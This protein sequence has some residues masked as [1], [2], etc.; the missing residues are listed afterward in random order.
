MKPVFLISLLLVICS[1]CQ[2]LAEAETDN[3][4]VDK[5]YSLFNSSDGTGLLY[6]MTEFSKEVPSTDRSEVL[7][8]II[9]QASKKPE[10]SQVIANIAGS[11]YNEGASFV[12]SVHLERSLL[13]QVK[14]G[15]ATVRSSII[16]LL[17]HKEHNKYR[18]ICLSSLEDPDDHVRKIAVSSI[19]RW[20]DGREI[21]SKY[22]KDHYFSP[23][24]NASVQKAE[25]MLKASR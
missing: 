12:W 20:D 24:H 7:A 6:A 3:K 5:Y 16:D 11:L 8:S 4:I 25:N 1:W 21:L 2:F 15:D 23:D 9:D 17:A 18:G 19:G 13:A 14:H 10:D 22:I